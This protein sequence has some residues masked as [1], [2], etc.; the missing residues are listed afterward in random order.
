M[1][2]S[3][4][5]KVEFPDK[6][7]LD[8]LKFL[9]GPQWLKMRFVSRQLAKVVQGNISELAC[10]KIDSVKFW[11]TSSKPSVL[12]ASNVSIPSNKKRD[13]FMKH[14]IKLDMPTGI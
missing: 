3:S 4:R 2:T 1:A 8:T 13:W 14:G 9:M 11:E 7:W 6:A 12:V 10:I 5:E